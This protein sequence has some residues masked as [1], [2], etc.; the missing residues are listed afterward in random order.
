M[1]NFA[2]SGNFLSPYPVIYG[3]LIIRLTSDFIAYP[4]AFVCATET[5]RRQRLSA[6]WQPRIG[7]RRPAAS[8]QRRIVLTMLAVKTNWFG[9]VQMHGW[10]ALS[11][12]MTE[13]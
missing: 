3:R 7:V 1:T 5:L 9:A 10:M 8:E 2:F 12:E 13:R 6:Y 11:G 4:N